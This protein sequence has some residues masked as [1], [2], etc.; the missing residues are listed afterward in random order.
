M[1]DERAEQ[2][3]QIVAALHRHPRIAHQHL[4]E[5]LA[6]LE[7]MQSSLP[8]FVPFGAPGYHGLL[9]VLDWDHKL[10][11]KI[12]ILRLY[13]YYSDR[14]LQAGQAEHAAR[15][16]QIRCRD[17]FPEFDV[18][19]YTG[20]TADEA[21]EGEVDEG[22]HVR[23]M[24]LVSPWRR[25]IEH[26]DA[27]LSVQLAR[28]SEE[29]KKLT[30][31]LRRRPDYLGDLE[32]VCWTPPCETSYTTW[33]VDVWYLTDLNASVG[34]G[35]SFLVDLEAKRVVGVREFVVRSG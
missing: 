32:A 7:Q 8:F 25:D 5:G 21:Y 2:A 14:T 22:G 4:A 35:R 16:D 18:P 13:A 10:P 28:R 15:M 31:E 24:R 9:P 23:Q 20:L 11:S 34:K 3:Q 19:D 30:A 6:H 33:T 17:V 26:D 1:T 12:A 29:F 27:H